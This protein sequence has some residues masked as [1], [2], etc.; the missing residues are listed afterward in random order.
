M[1]SLLIAVFFNGMLPGELR[2]WT[3]QMIA[4]ASASA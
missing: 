2:C 4:S 1:S 3:D